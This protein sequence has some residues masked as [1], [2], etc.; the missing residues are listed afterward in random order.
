MDLDLAA[1]LRDLLQSQL[2]TTEEQQP[3]AQHFAKPG[4]WST[5]L[6]MPCGLSFPLS[7]SRTDWNWC[8]LG[9]G[10]GFSS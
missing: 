4:Y 7:S 3:F 9:K 5:F 8:L 2:W 6:A 10:L 1:P